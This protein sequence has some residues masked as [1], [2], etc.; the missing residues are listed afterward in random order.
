MPAY[1]DILSM[2][3]HAKLQVHWLKRVPLRSNEGA[4]AVIFEKNKVFDMVQVR[5]MND[6]RVC[7]HIKS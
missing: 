3:S 6:R 5:V 2:K 7:Q 4:R 1:S